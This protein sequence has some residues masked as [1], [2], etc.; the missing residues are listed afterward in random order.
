MALVYPDRLH[1]VSERIVD[2]LPE[3]TKSFED[4]CEEWKGEM[5]G[6]Y[7]VACD[8]LMPALMGWIESRDAILLKRVFAFVED[9]A[10]DPDEIVRDFAQVGIVNVIAQRDD[11]VEVARPYMGGKT[12]FLLSR[13]RMI[14]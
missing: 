6:A 14:G 1:E 2:A 7:N 3:L 11:W 8:V 12:L 4:Y 13:S 9:L 5:P 10:N